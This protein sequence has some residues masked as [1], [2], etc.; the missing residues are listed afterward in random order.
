[1]EAHTL[2]HSLGR[3]LDGLLLLV[4]VVVLADLLLHHVR[5]ADERLL[6]PRCPARTATAA[7]ESRRVMETWLLRDRALNVS[8]LKKPG[9]LS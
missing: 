5:P 6:A 8:L 3:L 2:I 7:R 9:V 4:I 1:M